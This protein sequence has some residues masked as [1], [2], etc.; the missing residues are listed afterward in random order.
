METFDAGIAKDC[1]FK[2]GVDGCKLRKGFLCEPYYECI[3]F[4]KAY[5]L[6]REDGK[7]EPKDFYIE[8]G[9]TRLEVGLDEERR[10]RFVIY[11]GELDYRECKVV[12]ADE[13]K[14][15]VFGM[16]FQDMEH[17]GKLVHNMQLALGALSHS[18]REKSESEDCNG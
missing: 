8:P 6:G 17:F 7:S 5:E 14:V 15:P 2:C 16:S 3:S 12:P 1:P 9:H 13:T 18:L 11:V 10:P 4:K